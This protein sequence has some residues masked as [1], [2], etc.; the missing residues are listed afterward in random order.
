MFG[1]AACREIVRER[2]RKEKMEKC[3]AGVG[4]CCWGRM[5]SENRDEC[6]MTFFG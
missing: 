6:V 2:I 1:C 3:I 5:E 4:R